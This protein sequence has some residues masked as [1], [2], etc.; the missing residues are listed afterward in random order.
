VSW[1][2]WAVEAVIQF[3]YAVLVYFAALN[4]LYLVL[5][6]ISLGAVRR[7]VHKT[8][9]SDYGQ[10]RDSQMSWPISVLVPARNEEKTIIETIRSLMQVSYSEYEIIAINDGSTD[11]T[12]ERLIEEFG[13]GRV[14]RV[15]R[16]SLPTAAVRGIYT[17]LAHPNLTV[18]DKEPGGKADAL[19]AGINLSRY[20]LFCSI[21]ADSMIEENALLRVAK[22]FM[23]GGTETVAAGGI[24]RIVNGCRVRDGRVVRIELPDRPL[25][26]FQAVEYLRAF[27]AGR[28]GWSALQSL[29]IVSGAFAIFKKKIVLE[30]GGYSRNTET[31]DME[32]IVRLH[33]HLRRRGVDYRIVFVPDPVCWTEVPERL[34]TLLR[35]RTRWHRGLVR[36]LWQNRGM[37]FNPRYGSV[38]LF[39]F[40]YFLLFETLGPFIEILGYAAVVLAYFMELLNPEFFLLFIVLS[41]VYGAFLSIGAV[42][43]EEISFRRYPYWLDL[44]KLIV[45]GILENF[46][47]R[48]LLSLF[49]VKGFFDLLVLRR[50]WG[51]MERSGF[52]PGGDEEMRSNGERPSARAG[53]RGTTVATLLLAATLALSPQ[54]QAVTGAEGGA[55]ARFA[56]ARELAFERGDRAAA[57]ELCRAI[58]ETSPE[59]T[60]VRVFLGRLWAWDGDYP[61]ARE[62][63]RL[64][65]DARPD[66]ADARL[67]LIDVEL[68]DEQ[69]HSALA[70]AEEGLAARPDDPEL[71]LRQA[72]A[73]D[74]LGRRHEALAAAE[75]AW[76]ANPASRAARRHYVHLL[77]EEL[78]HRFSLD[79]EYETFDDDAID[80]WH[81]ASAAYRRVFGFGSLTGRVNVAD[82]FDDRGTQLEIDAYPDVGRNGYAYLNFGVS[83]SSLFPERRYGAEYFH[84][85]AHGFEGSLGLRRLDFDSSDVTIYTGALAKY[86]GP[87]WLAWRP[88]WVDKDDGSSY[89]N[90]FAVRRF[91]GGRYEYAELSL[92]GGTENEQ[93]LVTGREDRLDDFKVSADVRRRLTPRL[94]LKGSAG[95][96]DQEFSFGSRSSYFFG[97]GLD[98]FF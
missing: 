31:E 69:P 12:L 38:G 66:H 54:L 22:P 77:E 15:Y 92:S 96:R 6:L 48:Q 24:V 9:F 42:L 53:A 2:P 44:M 17:S 76:R 93:N 94:L 20:P 37:A 65:L 36:S 89:S 68:W 39:A 32:L 47:Y 59:Y 61:A 26:V 28:V 71:R 62:Q 40:P 23:E 90:G 83:S 97:L 3:N 46:G 81:L 29:L 41:M 14:D 7:F 43:L 57:R 64:A 60:D 95:Y 72:R 78:P 5:F 30:L 11:A 52:K 88:N 85:F 86:V 82:R 33:R 51:R 87:F 55:D 45:C 27:L 4:T 1:P 73:L 35:Q 98:R 58:L 91:L 21:D 19:N 63:L 8:F 13:L 75:T 18:I 16:R 56:Q 79:Y 84:N 10:I 34:G 74:G 49:K 67:A 70:L 25:P 80:D 50:G